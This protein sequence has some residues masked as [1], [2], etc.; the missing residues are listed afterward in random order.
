MPECR[1]RTK[2][3]KQMMPDWIFYRHSM[4]M[5]HVQVDVA[6]P[7]PCSMFTSMLHVQVHAACTYMS[8]SMLHVHVRAACPCP[9]CKSIFVLHVHVHA[10]CPCPVAS[11]CPSVCCRSMSMSILNV[12]VCVNVHVHAAYPCP[13][14][15][16]L[17]MS[18]LHIHINI[19]AACRCQTE[20][21]CPLLQVH[22]QL[23]QDRLEKTIGQDSW[24]KIIAARQIWQYSQDRTHG[25]RQFGE[26]RLDKS[27]WRV[28]LERKEGTGRQI[29]FEK[30]YFHEIRIF[31]ENFLII[32]A[33]TTIS[34]TFRENVRINSLKFCEFLR[35]GNAGLSPILSAAVG[36]EKYRYR[37]RS[38]TRLSDTVKHFFR[39]STRYACWNA[40]TG[41]SFLK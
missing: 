8:M 11:R 17:P 23:G 6:C 30:V 25:T 39:S 20:C 37:N 22:G 36:R 41:V 26:V 1:C 10:T 7:G 9:C 15:M 3:S 24:V 34:L 38:G 28:T 21:P 12:C 4:T 19:H 33:K 31:L 27:A 32:F 40:D 14:F 18:T 2:R 29:H 5:L 13:C 16:L 35:C